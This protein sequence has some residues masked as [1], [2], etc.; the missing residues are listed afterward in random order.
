M[1]PLWT[2][3]ARFYCWKWRYDTEAAIALYASILKES[4]VRFHWQKPIF[5]IFENF[6]QIYYGM[7]LLVEK[8]PCLLRYRLCVKDL[9]NILCRLRRLLSALCQRR[10]TFHWWI[11][12]ELRSSISILHFLLDYD[13][14]GLQ[15][16]LLSQIRIFWIIQGQ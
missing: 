14:W 4:E 16:R 1:Y 7:R 6:F 5:K 2:I 8:L 13:L 9:K 12:V 10:K 11:L 3:Q 15:A